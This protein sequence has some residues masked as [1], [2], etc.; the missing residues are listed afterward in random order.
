MAIRQHCR[1]LLHPAPH[2]SVV[3]PYPHLPQINR[4]AEFEE[5][6]AQQEWSEEGQ[7]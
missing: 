4:S 6:L 5:Y 2:R 3:D 1:T 7:L